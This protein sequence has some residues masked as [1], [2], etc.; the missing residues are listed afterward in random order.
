VAIDVDLE[1]IEI[2]RKL[3][4]EKGYL[5]CNRIVIQN[6]KK[7]LNEGF[8]DEKI[9]MYLKKLYVYFDKKIEANQSTADFSNYR[10]VCGF[11]EP[12]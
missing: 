2:I 11:V 12:F 6:I 4:Q 1:I 8:D 7:Q 10:Y 5:D 9:I 3:E